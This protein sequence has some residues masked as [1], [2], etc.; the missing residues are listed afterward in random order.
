MHEKIRKEK[1]RRRD[2]ENVRSV[3][4]RITRSKRNNEVEKKKHDD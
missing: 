2:A 1:M 4:K 3:L